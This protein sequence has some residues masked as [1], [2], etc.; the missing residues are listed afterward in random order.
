MN[1][2]RRSHSATRLEIRSRFAPRFSSSIRIDA[3]KLCTQPNECHHFV[4]IDMK[5]AYI[6]E[7]AVQLTALNSLLTS[8]RYFFLFSDLLLIAKQN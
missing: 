1:S 2:R 3:A 4:G 7:G 5:R 8:S 6:K